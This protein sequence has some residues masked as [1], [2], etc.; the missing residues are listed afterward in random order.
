MSCVLVHIF[1]KESCTLEAFVSILARRWWCIKTGG[2]GGANFTG[3]KGIL[4]Y[5]TFFFRRFRI[6]LSIYNKELLLGK[7]HVF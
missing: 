4:H 1:F 2:G 5:G 3:W 6:K 7:T